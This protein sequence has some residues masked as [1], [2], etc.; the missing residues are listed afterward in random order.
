MFEAIKH[1]FIEFLMV[2]TL[3]VAILCATIGITLSGERER[4]YDVE[5]AKLGCTQV[6]SGGGYRLWDCRKDK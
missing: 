4:K 6:Y 5:M 2:F 1:N 3:I